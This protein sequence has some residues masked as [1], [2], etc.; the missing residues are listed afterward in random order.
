MQSHKNLLNNADRSY[1]STSNIDSIVRQ[2]NDNASK[3]TNKGGYTRNSTQNTA[4][5][6][7]NDN[8]P[9][10]YGDISKRLP[11]RSLRRVEASEDLFF[12]VNTIRNRESAE[13]RSL[14]TPNSYNSHT[15]T[16]NVVINKPVLSTLTTPTMSTVSEGRMF[17]SYPESR[18][19]SRNASH[20]KMNEQNYTH[21]NGLYDT[22][23]YNNTPNNTSNSQYVVSPNTA[24][25]NPQYVVSPLITYGSNNVNVAYAKYSPV[26]ISSYSSCN[27][28]TLPH[29]YGYNNNLEY[30]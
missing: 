10:V 14:Y 21:S 28:S 19:S 12:K 20:R 2:F 18:H 29:D 15:P 6:R 3:R 26:S 25:S 22:N 13:S 1:D 11:L 4:S 24:A 5:R 8:R 30:I 9:L 16:P 27:T 17:G 7:V 23:P